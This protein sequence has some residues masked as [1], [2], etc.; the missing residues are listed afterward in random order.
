M[1]VKVN[2]FES[3]ILFQAAHMAQSGQSYAEALAS[4]D[5][6]RRLQAIAPEGATRLD[7]RG[8]RSLSIDLNVNELAQLHW[9][10]E[11]GQ[12]WSFAKW[13]D[14]IMAA[15]GVLIERMAGLIKDAQ[16]KDAFDALPEDERQRAL[17]QAKKE[18]DG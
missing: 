2:V 3:A 9:Q 16:A 6:A 1:H 7:P 13:T 18:Q 14:E 10:L 4:R 8:E 5:L 15:F 17:A 12:H 11:N